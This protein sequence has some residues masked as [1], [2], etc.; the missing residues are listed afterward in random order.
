M[1]KLII[2][3]ALTGAEVTQEQQPNLPITPEEIAE[4][5][6]KAYKAGASIVHVHAREDN[7]DPT[8]DYEKYKAIKEKVEAR[9]PV[10]FQP[11]TGGATWHSAEERLQP[12]E[13]KPEMATLSTG[14]CNFGSDVFMNS[15]EYMK[16]F[17][18]KMKEY[19]VKPELEVFEPGMIKN[20]KQLV[21][22]DL[23]E[24]PLHF[25]FVLGV[26]GALGGSAKNLMFMVDS[27]PEGSTW[28]VAGIGK[29]ETPLAAIAIAMGGHVR[30]G[31]EDNIYYSKNELATS[32]AQLVDR[33]TRIAD[34]LDR[35]VATP[36]E[37]REILNIK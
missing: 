30:V 13:L 23:V 4:A 11:S 26:P 21:K 28:T 37:A 14:T 8:Q 25:D 22:K 6:E 5:A 15:W 2:T 35:E 27:I 31:F 29:H 19:G 1:D 36:D 24:P 10:I 16:K 20:A 32:N 34:E 12:V 18:T 33:V 17:A 9:C 7:G 3:A